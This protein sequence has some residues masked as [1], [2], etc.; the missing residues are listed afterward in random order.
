MSLGN[1]Y[2][3]WYSNSSIGHGGPL[4]APFLISRIY[5]KLT[6]KSWLVVIQKTRRLRAV[7]VLVATVCSYN[8]W[9]QG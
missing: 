6:D 8:C 7:N 4:V 9:A 3:V 1:T 2:V 5:I